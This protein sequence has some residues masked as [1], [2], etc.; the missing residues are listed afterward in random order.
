M[1]RIKF[2][3]KFYMYTG[4]A[5]QMDNNKTFDITKTECIEALNCDQSWPVCLFDFTYKNR[6]PEYFAF[7]VDSSSY[8]IIDNYF[9]TSSDLPSPDQSFVSLS[10]HH[11]PYSP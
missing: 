8:K 10:N 5:K 9:N 2:L 7:R 1:N 11:G 3:N 6:V 4:I